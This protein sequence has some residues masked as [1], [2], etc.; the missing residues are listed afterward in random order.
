MRRTI[1]ILA[2]ALLCGCQTY[3]GPPADLTQVATPMSGA[4]LRPNETHIARTDDGWRLEWLATPGA[5]YQVETSADMEQWRVLSAP[6]PAD[7]NPLATALQAWFPMS[8]TVLD[9]ARRLTNAFFRVRLV[10]NPYVP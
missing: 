3:E 1:S 5:F 6:L 7:R 4:V 9:P 2:L 8:A 10:P